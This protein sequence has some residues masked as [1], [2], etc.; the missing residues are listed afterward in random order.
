M[1]VESEAQQLLMSHDSFHVYTPLPAL[2]HNSF[3]ASQ[4]E[5]VIHQHQS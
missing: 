4:T 2:I 3:A 5:S 1:Y